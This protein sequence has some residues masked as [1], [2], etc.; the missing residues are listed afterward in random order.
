MKSAVSLRDL[1]KYIDM[2]LDDAAIRTL[3]GPSLWE[4]DLKLAR[5]AIK[6]P[7]GLYLVEG[8]L[9]KILLAPSDT[10]PH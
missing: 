2:G 3:V 7:D 5:N 1:L 4:Y 9:G 8:N 10:L 6:Q